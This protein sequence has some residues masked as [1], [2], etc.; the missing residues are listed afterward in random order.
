[1]KTK[2][3]I[4]KSMFVL[5]AAS[6]VMTSCKKKSDD[7][8]TDSSRDNA[9]AEATYGDVANIAD[10]AGQK[11]TVSNYKG[12][13]NTNLLTTCATVSFTNQVSTDQD[14]IVVDFGTFPGCYGPDGRQ[15]AGQVI[16]YYSGKYKTPGSSHTIT[17][18]NYYVDKNKVEGTKTVT[19]NGLNSNGNMSWSINV[20]GKITLDASN[21]GGTITWTSSRTRELIAG[22]NA[23]D[24]TI[25]WLSSKWSITGSANGTTAKGG[26][27]SAKITSALVR[28]LTCAGAGRQIFT[29]GAVDITPNS[30]PTRSIDFGNGDCD[31]VAVV[32]INGK[33]YKV[34]LR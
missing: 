3:L 9:Y 27:F 11:G 10:E 24:S 28:D 21:G 5:T 4:L 31:N 2:N 6:L 13:E 23:A 15:R 16:V 33:Q 14:T 19:N 18:N 30:K 1:M 26:S 20:N 8:D 7:S 34:T 29:K 32:T 22:W 12:P 25:T 17:F